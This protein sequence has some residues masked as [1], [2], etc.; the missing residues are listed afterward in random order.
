MKHK[1][2]NQKGSTLLFVSMMISFLMVMALAVAQVILVEVKIGG[3]FA[4][5][6]KAFYGKQSA[7]ELSFL[8]K[9]NVSLTNLTNS[10]QILSNLTSPV[11]NSYVFNN[12]GMSSA[13][14]REDN[15]VFVRP[16]IISTA[17]SLHALQTRGIV[18]GWGYNSQGELCR[19][20]AT[21]AEQTPALSSGLTDVVTIAGGGSTYDHFLALKSDGKI[22]GCGYNDSGQLGDGSNTSRNTPVRVYDVNLNNAVFL[23][24][25]G[26]HSLAINSNGSIYGWGHNTSGQLG[27]GGT[28]S[29]NRPYI[30]SGSLTGISSVYA[31]L[32]H[33]IALKNDGAVYAWGGNSTGQLG[34]NSTDSNR[35]AP[36]LLSGISSV[37]SVATGGY[38]T[39]AL[40]ND[41][42]VYAWGANNYGQLGA[43]TTDTCGGWSCT[44]SP[45]LIPGLNNIVAITAGQ[46]HS[47]AIKADGT[48]YAWGQ[49]LA[50]QLG[51]GTDVNKSIPTKVLTLSSVI[52][53]SAGAWHSAAVK[54]DGSVWVWGD[55]PGIQGG[56]P[57]EPIRIQIGSVFLKL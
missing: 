24:S 46:F 26:M 16:K 51:D 35:T 19:G 15:I 12:R 23:A 22:W 30:V 54:S 47:L 14:R 37:K 8:N 7:F 45:I 28:T 13:I 34:I 48:V 11:L 18:W 53:I 49:N 31:G 57:F 40:K 55:Y 52:S 44:R 56:T 42:T 9:S 32:F 6:Q 3:D 1:K 33:S 20:T 10:T 25:G 2:L 4:S 39:L 38:H 29:Q 43:T 41:G 27:N 21:F 17:H 36:A 50:G 5:G